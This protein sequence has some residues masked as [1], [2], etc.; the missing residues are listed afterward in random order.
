MGVHNFYIEKLYPLQN[1]FLKFFEPRNAGRFY[2]TGG[3][4]LSRCYYQHR[5]SD[6]LDFFSTSQLPDFRDIVKEIMDSARLM[7]FEIDVETQT[8]HFLRIYVKQN[9]VALKVDFVNEAVFRW[10]KLVPSDIFSSVD[11]E[12]NILAN[13]ITCVSR[14]EVKDMADIWIIAKHVLFSWREVM[15]IA[16]KKSPIDPVDVSRI[17]KSLPLGEISK[18]IWALDV[19]MKDV[20]EN[21]QIVARDILLGQK[22]TLKN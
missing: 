13:K 5:F 10:G 21:L 6:D 19:N 11:N 20:H 9:D 4:A 2:L 18:V 8:D 22:N 14:Q 3:T 7:D 17:I 12:I 1:A 16:N 15:D